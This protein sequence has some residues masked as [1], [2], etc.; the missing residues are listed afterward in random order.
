MADEDFPQHSLLSLSDELTCSICLSIFDHP[1]TTPCG[2]NFCQQCLLDTWK[3]SYNCP[4]CRCVYYIKPELK[5]NTVLSAVVETYKMRSTCEAKTTQY[6]SGGMAESKTTT[7]A[8]VRCDTCMTAEAVKTC[9]TCMASYCA[10]HLRPHR[11]NP[12]F[13]VHQLTDCVDD[14]LERICPDH[15]KLM[16]LFCTQHDCLICTLCFQQTHKSCDFISP[17]QQR[18]KQESSLRQKLDFV[19]KKLKKNE[20]VL[21]QME[22]IK[23]ALKG[24]ATTKKKAMAN[25]YQQIRDMLAAEERAAMSVVDQ[26]LESSQTKLRVLMKRFSENIDSLST[27]KADIQSLLSQSQKIYFLQV[28][29]NLP[30][31]ATFDPYTPRINLDSKLLTANEEFA[32]NLKKQMNYILSQPVNARLPI[33]KTENIPT[34]HPMKSAPP[35]AKA[36]KVKYDKKTSQKK[37]FKARQHP[38]PSK[39][40]MQKLSYSMENLLCDTKPKL[41][42]H[43]SETPSEPKE[44]TEMMDSPTNLIGEKRHNLLKYGTAVSFDPMTAHKRIILTE[45][46]T[47]ASV[48]DQPN[49]TTYND[50]PERFS[51]CSQVGLSVAK[52]VACSP[53]PATLTFLHYLQWQRLVPLLLMI[54]LLLLL[55]LWLP[56]EEDF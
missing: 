37:I 52:S 43:L 56:A 46:F 5:K 7:D 44:K 33:I 24:S 36:D 26:E 54:L 47:R 21:S 53:P 17:E 19:D 8:S 55:L 9:L 10:E 35:A 12:V 34:V 45:G 50:C 3:E 42:P 49:S 38:E 6:L 30:K 25:E 2:H 39:I 32:V 15:H 18:A 31:A 4:Q 28:S 41:R 51:V 23:L 40:G 27:S 22:D 11:E 1:V 16:E 14:L 29:L 48:S 13:R 20:T